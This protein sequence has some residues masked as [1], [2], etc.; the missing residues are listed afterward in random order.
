MAVA[1]STILSALALPAPDELVA[2]DQRERRRPRP[3]RS[4]IATAHLID[5]PLSW[6]C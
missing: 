2:I 1:G 3:N 5:L 4:P 6:G